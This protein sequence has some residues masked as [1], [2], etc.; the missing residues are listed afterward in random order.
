MQMILERNTQASQAKLKQKDVKGVID[1]LSKSRASPV[2]KQE[3]G[4]MA[5][6]KP[7]AWDKVDSLMD[8]LGLNEEKP[9]GMKMASRDDTG[10]D[11]MRV[12]NA[13]L[14]AEIEKL[15][16]EKVQ[17]NGHLKQIMWKLKHASATVGDM[18]QNDAKKE[19]ILERCQGIAK[20]YEAI[21][22]ML[23]SP[24]TTDV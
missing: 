4:G 15:E 17:F 20:I 13:E 6:K 5:L 22:E 18:V 1:S 24:A 19:A 14:K 23:G 2:I 10:K 7:S 16:E 21:D 11:A 3:G 8:G 9:I 12:E